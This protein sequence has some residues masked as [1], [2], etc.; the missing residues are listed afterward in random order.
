MHSPAGQRRRWPTSVQPQRKR[1]RSAP[2]VPVLAL[3]VT[4]AGLVACAPRASSEPQSSPPNATV[5]RTV[6][7]DTVDLDSDIRGRIRLCVIGINAPEVHKRGWTVGCS[8]P[9]AAAWAAQ[10]LP[11]GQRVAVIDDPTQ[12]SHDRYGR[13]YLH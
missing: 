7:G 9:E 6:D 12:D 13:T 8:G 2:L 1:R 10:T 4:T 11:A 5:I 3:A